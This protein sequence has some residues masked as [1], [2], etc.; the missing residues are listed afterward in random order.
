MNSP[1]EGQ[2]RGARV[3]FFDLRLNKQ[4]SK[5]P[6]HRFFFRRRRAHHDVT[7]MNFVGEWCGNHEAVAITIKLNCKL[8]LFVI[9]PTATFFYAVQ[10]VIDN[11]FLNTRSWIRLYPCWQKSSPYIVLIFYW[12]MLFLY[13]DDQIWRQF[14][15][16]WYWEST[17]SWYVMS[18]DWINTNIWI[19]NRHTPRVFLNPE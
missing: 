15:N 12:R 9:A 18:L 14:H 11:D 6:R 19:V 1:H 4:L 16:D 10:I 7:V 2:W 13:K 17:L 8:N 3:F 5:P